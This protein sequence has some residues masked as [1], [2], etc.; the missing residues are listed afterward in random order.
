M[1]LL[2]MFFVTLKSFAL[3]YTITFTA[4][5][6]S[7]TVGSVIVQ[8]LTKGTT[9]TVPSGN[10][11]NLTNV[12]T[13]LNE[14]IGNDQGISISQSP[15]QGK[16]TL[17]FYAKQ[18]GNVQISIFGMD[19]KNVMGCSENLT[20]GT[21]S[22]LISLPKGAFAIKVTGNGYFYTTKTLN[23]SESESKPEIA[24]LGNKEN[25]ASVRQKAKSV[26]TPMLFAEGDRL[27]FKGLSG[28]F[29]TVVLDSPIANQFIN[30]NF[31]ACQDADLNNYP[32]VVIG[33][34]TWMAENLKTTKYRDG[35]IITDGNTNAAWGNWIDES[36]YI[37]MWCNYN[38][39]AA[40]GIKYGKL[41]DGY[42]V[43]GAKK[44]A[45]TGWHIATNDE[46][47]TLNA[48]L[49]GTWVAGGKLKEVGFI[50]WAA[51]LYG[52]ATNETGFTALP[53]GWRYDVGTFGNIGM[54]G[55]WWTSTFTSMD[56]INYWRIGYDYGTLANSHA[57]G[58]TTGFSVRCV[59]D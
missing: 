10:T 55:Y 38:Q 17:S 57:S 9:V 44:I 31:V 54:Q 40:N 33:T 13:S 53:G 49:G 28:D 3:D 46:W 4:S 34:Q 41:Y 27:L 12:A 20:E 15:L 29:G 22:F 30:F 48:F 25:D 8:N 23:I 36:G 6:A 45:P 35:S 32:V 26:V 1:T 7:S 56:W 16:S 58:Y 47:T 14:L 59:K 52:E 43:I 5:G 50:N 39:D 11:L 42:A 19:G 2:L 51:S 24:F 18:A 21:N 37:G